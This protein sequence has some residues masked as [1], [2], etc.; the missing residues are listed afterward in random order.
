M[1]DLTFRP[2][3]SAVSARECSRRRPIRW[4]SPSKPCDPQPVNPTHD[5]G[6]KR[7]PWQGPPARPEPPGLTNKYSNPPA[8]SPCKHRP[9]RFTSV[10][11]ERGRVTAIMYDIPNVRGGVRGQNIHY[12]PSPFRVGE[13]H[14]HR[15]LYSAR[16]YKGVVMIA[17]PSMDPPRLCASSPGFPPLLSF[18]SLIVHHRRPAS[19]SVVMEV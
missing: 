19:I 10:S 2:H 17:L 7:R 11:L 8:S 1:P 14:T 6:E 3:F 9:G 4:T 5:T 18:Q 16:W 12:I 13:S 15:K